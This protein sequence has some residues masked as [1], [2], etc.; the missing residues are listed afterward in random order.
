MIFVIDQTILKGLVVDIEFLQ[1]L[2][3]CDTIIVTIFA[4]IPN[5]PFLLQL[6]LVGLLLVPETILNAIDYLKITN[7][8]LVIG[9]TFFAGIL[10]LHCAFIL[11]NRNRLLRQKFSRG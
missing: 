1:A 10:A 6:F 5:K 7:Q 4:D 2:C 3:A 11:H 9:L 8:L